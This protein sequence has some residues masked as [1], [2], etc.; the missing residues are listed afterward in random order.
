MSSP[1]TTDLD[2]LLGKHMLSL[3]RLAIR[4]TGN[5]ESSEDILQ[6]SML[7]IVQNW[8]NFQQQSSFKTWAIRI[9]VNVFRDWLAKRRETLPLD[10]LADNRH[11][12]PALKVMTDEL[13]RFIAHCVSALPPRQREVIVLLVYEGLAPIEVS[14][15]LDMQMANVYATLYQARKRLRNEL[16][17]FL[18]TSSPAHSNGTEGETAVVREDDHA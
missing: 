4:L 16:A 8:H 6:E 1:E 12:D 2:A 18:P 15:I 5:R 3:Q 10:D 13:R 14:Q 17:P 7:R 11:T 9:V